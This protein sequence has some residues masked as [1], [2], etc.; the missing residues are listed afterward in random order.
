MFSQQ[1]CQPLLPAIRDVPRPFRPPVKPILYIGCPQSERAAT[2]KLLAGAGLMV[3]AG[4]V[5]AVVA[6]AVV[7]VIAG[8]T[9]GLS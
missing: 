4:I 3:L 9:G 7:W 2:E 5:F 1:R 8:Q 6:T